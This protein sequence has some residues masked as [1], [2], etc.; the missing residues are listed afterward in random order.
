MNQPDEN[1]FAHCGKKKQDSTVNTPLALTFGDKFRKIGPYH[2]KQGTP[3]V[4]HSG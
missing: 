3:G 1:V 4:I 2:I